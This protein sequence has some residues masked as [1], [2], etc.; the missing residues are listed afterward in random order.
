MTRMAVRIDLHGCMPLRENDTSFLPQLQRYRKAGFDAVGINA[1]FDAVEWQQ[2][3]LLL[4]HF[5]R[6]L[7]NHPEEYQIIEKPDDF[8]AA[9][10]Q[11]KLGVFFDIEGGKA[12]NSHI[13]MVDVYYRLGV[14]WML[15][16]YN[17]ANALGG[18]CMDAVDDGLTRFGRQVIEQMAETGMLL[19]CTHCGY[20]TAAE[21][22]EHNPNPSIFSHSNPRSVYDHARNIP[23]DLMKRCAGRGGVVGINGIGVFLGDNESIPVRV[24]QHIDY[25]VQKI[26]IR[27]V[28]LGLDYVF[29]TEELNA[30]LA[31]HPELFPTDRFRTV[32]HILP[33]EKLSDLNSEL[34][35]LGYQ[36]AD[37]DLIFGENWL[38]VIRQVW[39]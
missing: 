37:I 32:I 36:D 39:K 15:L 10:R 3:V 24:A 2:T 11:G 1:G 27:H 7:Q 8:A 31:K 13:G 38:R 18:G 29:D 20:K 22:I 9:K 5:R 12:L 33:P 6:F 17:T 4:A 16:A 35:R 26:G 23:D 14:R 34:I 30:F 25:A 21:A 19:C 28:G